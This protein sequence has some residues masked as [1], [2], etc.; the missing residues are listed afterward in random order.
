MVTFQPGKEHNA[1]ISEDQKYQGHLYK[2]KEK[3]GASNKRQS[4]NGHD[5]SKAMIPRSAYMEDAP[6]G[7][8]SNAVAALNVPPRA[9]TPPSAHEAL[10]ENVNVFDFLVSDATPGAFPQEVEAPRQP[11]LLEERV[12]QYVSGDSQ[13]SQ[14]SNGNGSQY[15]QHGFSYGNA[16]VEPTFQ[17]YDSWQNMNDLQQPHTL[18]PPPPYVTPGPKTDRSDHKSKSE[19]SDKKRKRQQVE[20][21]DLSSA[22]R[23]SSRDHTSSHNGLRPGSGGKTLHSGLTG[24]LSRLVTDPEFF[25]DRIDAG[26]TPISPIKRTKRDK[27]AKDERRKSS[28]TSYSTTTIKPP[29]ASTRPADDRERRSYSKEQDRES[30]S[31][32]QRHERRRHDSPDSPDDVYRT[33]RKPHRSI[34]YASDRPARPMSVQPT[35]TNQVAVAYSS[36]AELFLSFV[37]KGPDSDKGCSINKALKRYHRE[38]DVKGDDKEDD[39]K[40]LWKSLRLRKNERGEIVLFV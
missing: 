1:C 32:R 31:S 20:E 19:K 12:P 28:Y 39:D 22:K 38:R 34:E 7:D 5:S 29:S 30:Q 17:R 8:D 10:P 24:G 9:P 15:L 33:A 11:A 25:D 21:L 2:E 27:D 35:S 18:M 16:P 3:K 6:E 40:E 14:H 37:N 13:Y 23:P 26:P 36:R 4:T